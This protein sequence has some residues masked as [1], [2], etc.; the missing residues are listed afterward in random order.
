MYKNYNLSIVRTRFRERLSTLREKYII[1]S[2]IP[3]NLKSAFASKDTDSLYRYAILL[4]QYLNVDI[5]DIREAIDKA[6]TFLLL[7]ADSDTANTLKNF[8]QN[9]YTDDKYRMD[10]L[11]KQKVMNPTYLQINFTPKELY[12]YMKYCLNTID[13]E[14]IKFDTTISYDDKNSLLKE[15]VSDA[16]LK[17]QDIFRCE[18]CGQTFISERAL[19]NHTCSYQ[20]QDYA[21]ICGICGFK[22]NDLSEFNRHKCS[23]ENRLNQ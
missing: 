12:D 5:K 18:R 21:Y 7:Y 13:A 9:F 10:F 4:V 15:A 23:F 6:Y 14:L 1:E 16:G 20:P 11:A 2:Y 22:T 17:P 8:L 3:S 19:E